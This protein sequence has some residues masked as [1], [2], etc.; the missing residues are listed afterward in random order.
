MAL[1]IYLAGEVCLETPT[2]VIF[3]RAFTG[4]QARLVFVRLVLQ[5]HRP[6]P[7]ATLADMLWP[8]QLLPAWETALSAIVST[9]RSV[10]VKVG[11]ERNRS[12]SSAFGCYRM[13][14]PA[15]TWVDIEAAHQAIDDAE[16]A[17]RSGM[18][19]QALGW[20]GIVTSV[21][22]RPFLPGEEGEWVDGHRARL[23]DLLV[24]GLNC[25]VASY[26]YNGEMAIAVRA[27]EEALTLEPFRE[28]G[29]RQLMRLH[30]GT[31]NRAEA[32]R[33]FERCRAI[34]AA[35]L[36]I[37]PSPETAALSPR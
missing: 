30:L 34:L 11:V 6:L 32:R 37:E 24:R 35:E 26:A 25:V 12:I 27:A 36:G 1:R 3:E 16:G 18:P 15:D 17:I 23:H 2:G 29:Y 4:R 7:R 9:L 10:L 14:L 13:L 33:V 31:G 8:E 21:A 20:A 5:R 28:S 22:R 19:G